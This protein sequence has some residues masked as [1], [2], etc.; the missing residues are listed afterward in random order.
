MRKKLIR[1]MLLGGVVIFSAACEKVEPTSLKLED[2]GKKATVCGYIYYNDTNDKIKAGANVYACVSLI[3]F[4]SALVGSQNFSATT[5]EKGFYTI[6]LPVPP[7]NSVKF[8]VKTDFVAKVTLDKK[9]RDAVFHAS[10]ETITCQAGQ[11]IV[12]N[13]KASHEESGYLDTLVKSK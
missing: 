5:N 3:Q 6:S 8:S 9:R 1:W 11:T 13:M 10:K 4:D 7:T 12:V 2:S